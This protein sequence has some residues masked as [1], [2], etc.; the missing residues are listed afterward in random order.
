[1]IINLNLNGNCPNKWGIYISFKSS[2]QKTKTMIK[3]LLSCVRIVLTGYIYSLACSSSE[4]FSGAFTS[5]LN[6]PSA[7]SKN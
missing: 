4:R 3:N 5:P 1:M 7:P 2:S 6:T